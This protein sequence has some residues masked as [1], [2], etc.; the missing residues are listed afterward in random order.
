[1][2]EDFK[3]GD[4]K[5]GS[6]SWSD[7]KNAALGNYN[8]QSGKNNDYASSIFSSSYSGM[9]EGGSNLNY[10]G[11]MTGGYKYDFPEEDYVYNPGVYASSSRSGSEIFSD[12]P[13]KRS[14]STAQRTSLQQ[15]RM[16]SS[17]TGPGTQQKVRPPEQKRPTKKK[18]EPKNKKGEKKKT[19]GK[20][21][22]SE[23]ETKKRQMPKDAKQVSQKNREMQRT[24]KHANET[25]KLRRQ[26]NESANKRELERQKRER[27][28]IEKNN[29][30]FEQSRS[31]GKS[32]DESRLEQV[33]KK[34]RSR[35]FHA[36]I[37]VCCVV[38]A[39]V[40]VVFSLCVFKGAPIE[41]IVI[42]GSKTYETDEILS[43][44]S[45]AKG[46][47]MLLIREKKTSKKVSTL[48]PYIESVEVK[49]E[50][51]D[52]LKLTVTETKDKIH[53]VNGKGY[54]CI[55]SNNKVVSDSKKKIAS[56]NYKLV[57]LESQEYTLGYTFEPNEEN[58]NEE[59]FKIAKEII[60][61][62]ETVG[63]EN[64]KTIDL[65]NLERISISCGKNLTLYV[66][67]KTPYQKR[68]ELAK[69]QI[70]LKSQESIKAYFDLR[71]DGMVVYKDG[72]LA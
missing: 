47:N 63:I 19:N 11:K 67:K 50:L 69:E 36:V 13:P 20:K 44:A 61:A 52:T 33:H 43:A 39:A 34:K 60:D 68:L 40:V 56:G 72:E 45:I 26:A 6:F 24:E 2:S 4:E 27:A 15:R 8:R 7:E 12:R 58:G 10:S 71:F 65:S 22:F 18:Q 59:K 55:D 3:N 1:M 64:C 62:L 25:A 48:L 54:I 28:Q 17:Q 46:D 29:R 37:W 30:R 42:E 35:K 14:D 41:N 9:G 53:I 23:S 49:Y 21:H 57:G 16:P 70:E 32:A 51:P 31:S 38:F 66:N 5:K